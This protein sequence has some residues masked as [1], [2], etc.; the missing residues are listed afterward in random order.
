V[1][2]GK[3]TDGDALC[4]EV[5]DSFVRSQYEASACHA[6]YMIVVPMLVS[7]KEDVGSHFWHFVAN[8]TERIDGDAYALRIFKDNKGLAI[9]A[10]RKIACKDGRNNQRADDQTRHMNVPD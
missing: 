4:L 1:E 5:T 3:A 6:F 9:P 2:G 7:N 10:N 8:R